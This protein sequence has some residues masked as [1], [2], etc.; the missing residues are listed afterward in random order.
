VHPTGSVAPCTDRGGRHFLPFGDP[1]DFSGDLP[2]DAEAVASGAAPWVVLIVD[3]DRGVHDATLLAL[4]GERILGRPLEFRHAYA[5]AE[6]HKLLAENRD[7]AVV[8]LDVV[9]ES[10]DAGLKLISE[11]RDELG[12]S[13]VKIIVRTGQPGRAPEAQIRSS[14]AIDGY[15]TKA[16]LTRAMLLEALT[17]VLRTG[18]A[19]GGSAQ[20]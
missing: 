4:H 7:I 6:A 10:P 18:E 3:D 13:D 9:M 5:A 2:D 8:L 11:I 20:H 15:I 1:V 12:Q 14:L 17:Q 19:S 16:T